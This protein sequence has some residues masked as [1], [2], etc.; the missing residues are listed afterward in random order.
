MA[1]PGAQV[2]R[3]DEEHWGGGGGEAAAHGKSK[4]DWRKGGNRI[5][6]WFFVIWQACSLLSPLL[7]QRQPKM[8]W[9]LTYEA[10]YAR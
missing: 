7:G 8:E 1:V 3:V 4:I 2:V 5:C 9:V 6:P 10:F